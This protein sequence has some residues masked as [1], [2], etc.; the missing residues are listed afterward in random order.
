MTLQGFGN[1][2][3]SEGGVAVGPAVEHITAACRRRTSRPGQAS[4]LFGFIDHLLSSPILL[5]IFIF[6]VVFGTRESI[7]GLFLDGIDRIRTSRK[8]RGLGTGWSKVEILS[9]RVSSS[10]T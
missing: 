2:F 5:S 3:H 6:M 9:F 1:C 8:C 4:A 10:M 7:E